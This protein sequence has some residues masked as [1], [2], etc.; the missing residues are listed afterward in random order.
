MDSLVLQTAI[1][2]VF[3]FAVFAALVSVLTELIA[4]FIGLR[5]EYLL[6]GIRSLVDGPSTFELP[7]RDLLPRKSE[8]PPADAG[9]G[10]PAMVTRIMTHPLIKVSADKAQMP[11]Y[12]GNATLTNEQR[13][14]L[15]SYLSGRSFARALVDLVAPDATG[16]TTIDDIRKKISASD[17]PADLKVRLLDLAT[18]AG[19]DVAGFRRAI[20]EWYDDHMARVSGWYKRHVRWISF[21]LAAVL[22]LAFNISAVAITRSLYTDQALRGSVVTEAT[23]AAQCGDKSPAD[24]L[25]DVRR[26]IEQVR[27]AGLPIGWG[28]VTDCR[29]ASG[30]CGWLAARGLADP[31]G[32]GANDVGFFLLVLLG[33]ALMVVSLLPGARFWF[34][35]L[36]RLGT[37]R[38]TGP[39]PPDTTTAPSTGPAQIQLPI[40]IVHN[41]QSGAGTAEGVIS[42]TS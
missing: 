10:P 8:K 38:S 5:G 17:A 16:Q 2:L 34:D 15:P 35:L 28:T 37:L 1:G 26:Q 9:D 14:K 41:G 29:S 33:W 40:G 7:F 13:R 36:G 24:C 21:A 32:G 18:S 3:V 30:G 39:R 12:A 27:G 25:S 42:G 19:N 31:A 22:V 4:R 11:D 23:S 20:E 6:R